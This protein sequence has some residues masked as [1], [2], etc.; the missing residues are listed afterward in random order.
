MPANPFDLD[1][2]PAYREWRAHKLAIAPA[3][4]EELIVEIDD[5]RTLSDAEHAALSAC[6]RRANMAIY[7]SQIG[8]LEGTDT[9]K[10]CGQ[11]FG[12]YHLDHNRGAEADAVT[13][14]TVQDDALH[15]PYIPYSNRAIHWHTDGYYNRLDLQDHALL[16]HCVRP[17]MRGGENALMDHEMAYLLMRDTDPR[18]V[19]ALMHEDAMLIPKNVVDDVE[20]RPDRTGPVFMV[21]AD[22]HLH[23]RYTMRKRNVVW[24]DDPLV[25]DAVAWLENLLNSDSP[26]IFR[27]TLQSGWGLIS[28]N[29]LHD[30]SGFED[31]PDPVLK[32]LL[33][34]ARYHDRIARES[35][36]QTPHP[37]H[38]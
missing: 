16:L 13:A 24:K 28:N 7:K 36:R 9:V 25:H 19:R 31:A 29:V 20:L 8:A 2:E 37:C 38:A 4:L 12:L 23:M 27:A 22:G 21:A 6:C 33:Y 30:R 35:C 32:R 14:L 17:A 26:H 10:Q 15:T 18:F 34:R 5:P 3:A 1:N 11:R